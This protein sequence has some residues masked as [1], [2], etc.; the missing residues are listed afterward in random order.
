MLTTSVCCHPPYGRAPVEGG[1]GPTDHGHVDARPC[2]A[3]A[4]PGELVVQPV[5]RAL[6]GALAGDREGKE[7]L[8]KT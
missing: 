1:H 5:A 7:G 8:P 6:Q 2:P 3:V 4:E